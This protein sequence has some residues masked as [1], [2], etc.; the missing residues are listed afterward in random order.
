MQRYFVNNKTNNDIINLSN[1]DSHHIKNVMRMNLGDKIEIIWDN[2]LYLGEIID[3][4]NQVKAKVI[5]EILSNSEMPC[6][7]SIAQA[8][9]NEQ[10]MDYILQK[11]CELGVNEIIPIKTSR[12]IVKV[13]GKEEKKII[14]W[15]K[16]VKEAS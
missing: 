14:R 8:L 13:T 3:L 15:Q 6:Q 4:T 5:K 9:V 12:S 16:I 1:S 10:K 7:I 2:H 11:T